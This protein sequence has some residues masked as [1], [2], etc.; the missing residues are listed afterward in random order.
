MAFKK[1]A[2]KYIAFLYPNGGKKTARINLYCA[3]NH[4]LYLLFQDPS[5]ALSNNTYNESSKIGVAYLH[6]DQ[7]KDYEDL[8]RNEKPINVTFRPEDSP[9]RFVVYTG[10]EDPGEGEM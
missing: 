4:K 8:V 1:V 9:P 3:D 7:F 6:Y 10:W 2:D 5:D